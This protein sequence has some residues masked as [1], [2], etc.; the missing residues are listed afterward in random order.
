[1]YASLEHTRSLI[2]NISLQQENFHGKMKPRSH[3]IELATGLI[4]RVVSRGAPVASFSIAFRDRTG[5]S[6]DMVTWADLWFHHILDTR[7]EVTAEYTK[8]VAPS[9]VGLE[10][11][12]FNDSNDFT[13]QAW[14]DLPEAEEEDEDEDEDE[15]DNCKHWRV[16]LENPEMEVEV[17]HFSQD[18][19]QATRGSRQGRG[20]SLKKDVVH[21][22]VEALMRYKV[23]S[24]FPTC[25]VT[26]METNEIHSHRTQLNLSKHNPTR[27]SRYKHVQSRHLEPRPLLSRPRHSLHFGLARIRWIHSGLSRQDPLARWPFHLHRVERPRPLRRLVDHLFRQDRQ[28]RRPGQVGRGLVRDHR[29][30]KASRRCL[31]RRR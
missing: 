1:M 26:A 9:A 5:H 24:A 19:S 29:L 7:D 10:I 3:T 28:P 31:R 22:R 12:K 23:L 8:I 15:L 11:V 30:Q 27:I 16:W 13:C 21:G 25:Y 14:L 18:L 6:V 20:A 17:S 4:L 2:F